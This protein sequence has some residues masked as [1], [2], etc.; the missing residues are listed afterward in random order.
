[1]LWRSAPDAKTTVEPRDV[2]AA[3][4][5]AM[6]IRPAMRQDRGDTP[7]RWE[8]RAEMCRGGVN[9]PAPALPTGLRWRNPEGQVVPGVDTSVTVGRTP[10]AVYVTVTVAVP[11]GLTNVASISPESIFWSS[12]HDAL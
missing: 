4:Q 8:T 7:Q 10:Q 12:V 2:A 9:D 1:M 6:A 5:L 11:R 3:R